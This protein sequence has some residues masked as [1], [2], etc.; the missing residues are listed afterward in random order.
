[1]CASPSS[2]CPLITRTVPSAR[3]TEP[4]T[5]RGPY[6]ELCLR[7]KGGV[8]NVRQVV[9]EASLQDGCMGWGEVGVGAPVASEFL[10]LV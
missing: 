5:R 4:Y 3:R 9:V 6:I 10:R 8:C 1:M 2:S 7:R